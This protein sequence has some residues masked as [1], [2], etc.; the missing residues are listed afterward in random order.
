MSPHGASGTG[1]RSRT[2]ERLRH[3]RYLCLS[4]PQL[5]P[6]G[7]QARGAARRRS[8]REGL[9]HCGP[10]VP[11]D[12]AGERPVAGSGDEAVEGGAHRHTARGEG[13]RHSLAWAGQRPKGSSNQPSLVQPSAYRLRPPPSSIPACGRFRRRSLPFPFPFRCAGPRG[14]GAAQAR[15]GRG[16]GDGA[17]R[18]ARGG[19]GRRRWP[20]RCGG[21]GPGV[22]RNGRA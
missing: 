13:T 21:A 15:S 18:A 4:S 5:C 7:V 17:A 3:S 1:S 19:C 20:V 6:E 14:A 2:G 22:R 9:P 16:R 10:A 11:G 8:Q 12:R